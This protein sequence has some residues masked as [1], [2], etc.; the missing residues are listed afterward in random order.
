M[1]FTIEPEERTALH[2][3][4]DAEGYRV[5]EKVLAAEIDLAS[6]S[7][8]NAPNDHRYWQGKMHALF[9]FKCDLEKFSQPEEKIE[10]VEPKDFAFGGKP[11]SSTD[12]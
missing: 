4:K 7:L 6:A 12:Y 1:T 9:Q 5:F 10:Y 8:N 2:N 3:L 11:S